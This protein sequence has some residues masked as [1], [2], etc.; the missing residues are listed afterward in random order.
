M[1]LD[2]EGEVNM[3]WTVVVV[4]GEISAAVA[5]GDRDEIRVPD[6]IASTVNEMNGEWTKRR[7]V[8]CVADLQ[9]C[10]H[11]LVLGL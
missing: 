4:N 9:H 1:D 2:N 7:G 3:V 6:E 11:G 5:R 8:H 10:G